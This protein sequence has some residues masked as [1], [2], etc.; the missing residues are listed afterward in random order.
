M[1]SFSLICI[2]PDAWE[3]SIQAH[4]LLWNSKYLAFIFF[5]KAFSVLTVINEPKFFE[6]KISMA[7][8]PPSENGNLS[9][10]RLGYMSRIPFSI[11]LATC[12]ADK[13]PLNESGI[14][15]IFIILK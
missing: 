1:S 5:P 3:S 14:I 4:F 13:H 12:F 6:A 2:I 15:R 9:T 7:P 11:A 8:S 10:F